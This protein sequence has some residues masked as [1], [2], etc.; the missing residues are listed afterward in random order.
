MCSPY[1][2]LSIK[3]RQ[4]HFLKWWIMM[5]TECLQLSKWTIKTNATIFRL[6]EAAV[7]AVWS[8]PTCFITS[9]AESFDRS[10][11]R[12][13]LTQTPLNLFYSSKSE[14]ERE[15]FPKRGGEKRCEWDSFSLSQIGR[16]PRRIDCSSHLKPLLS[17][18]RSIQNLN[19]WELSH[20]A[21]GSN[22]HDNSCLA[23][24]ERLS[25]SSS[26]VRV[27]AALSKIC[28]LGNTVIAMIFQ[29]FCGVVNASAN[30][31]RFP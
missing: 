8:D 27:L 21:K 20:K 3:L 12:I 5:E 22:L 28:R 23:W 1:K 7:P 19:V 14:T 29:Q 31:S 2:T 15:H 13:T 9:S 17:F 30:E 18:C 16:R 25:K 26:A 10:W 4:K 6:L 24:Y 11:K